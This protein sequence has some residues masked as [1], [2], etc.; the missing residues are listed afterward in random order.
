MIQRIQSIWLLL[1]AL[2]SALLMLD[3]YTGWLYIESAG[4]AEV[5]RL[6]TRAH[7]DTTIIAGA[8]ILLPLIAIF[9]FRNRKQQKSLIWFSILACICFI[10]VMLAHTNLGKSDSPVPTTGSYQAGAVLPA[11]VIVFLILA[12]RGISKDDKLVKS[13]DRLR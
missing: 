1:A 4:G 7:I 8:M 3:W 9:M 6:V 2:V 12:L 11:I 13:M 5:S 10:G